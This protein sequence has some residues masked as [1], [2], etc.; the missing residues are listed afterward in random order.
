MSDFGQ[1]EL[2]EATGMQGQT[3]LGLKGGAFFQELAFNANMFREG[4][5]D[6]Y[7]NTVY[8]ELLHVIVNKYMIEHGIIKLVNDDV[9]VVDKEFFEAMEQDDGHG[10]MW[11]ELAV[12][13]NKVLDLAIPITSHCNDTE[14]EK[15]FMSSIDDYDDYAFEIVCQDCGYGHKWLTV[16]PHELPDPTFLLAVYHDTKKKLTNSCCKKCG[17]TMYIDIKDKLFEEFI[18][19]KLRELM[20]AAMMA[21]LFGAS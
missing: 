17:G 4:L 10:G 21:K 16:N 9:E 5:E 13:A 11:L 8:H 19:K 12:R 14:M 15:V 2:F 6:I 3:R 20:F 7:L 1:G 18:D